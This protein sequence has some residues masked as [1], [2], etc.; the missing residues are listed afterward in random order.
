MSIRGHKAANQLF[1]H[2]E[3][4]LEQNIQPYGSLNLNIDQ[5]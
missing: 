3:V 4:K 5:I 2:L 1:T